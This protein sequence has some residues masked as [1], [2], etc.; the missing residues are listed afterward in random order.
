MDRCFKKSINIEVK[1]QLF[2]GLGKINTLE[3]LIFN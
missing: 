3:Y 1:I 2:P